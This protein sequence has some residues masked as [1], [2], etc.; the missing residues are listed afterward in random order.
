MGNRQLD[1]A[2]PDIPHS[3][4]IP[5]ECTIV[6][7]NITDNVFQNLQDPRILTNTVILTPTNDHALRMNDTI[8]RK[9]PGTP[10]TYASADRVICKDE[11]EAQQYPLEFLNS[12][13]PTGMP[14]HR[15][16]L[17]PG[18]IVMLLRNLD[19]RRGLCNGTRLIV[20]Q[21]HTHVIDAEIL[22]G[23]NKGDYVLIPRIKLAPSD[24]NLPF[25]LERTQFPLKV[26]YCMTINKAQG[27]TFDKLGIFLPQ[28]VFIHEQL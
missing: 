4:R 2:H 7:D 3:I 13:T 19:I 20:R 15:L 21:L 16:I 25:I 5:K 1:N 12:L 14:P 24:V 23:A 9:L 10:K 6:K 17:K 28:S 8:T 22:T 26:S 27:Q 11:E 18:V